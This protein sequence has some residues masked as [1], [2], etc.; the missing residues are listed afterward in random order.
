MSRS[1]IQMVKCRWREFRREPS[2]FFFVITMPLMWM[3]ILGYSFSEPKKETF[4]I[5]IIQP[6]KVT[7]FHTQ[8]RN[9]LVDRHWLKIASGSENE[10]IQ[11]L[12]KEEISL[13]VSTQ[14]SQGKEEVL[15]QFNPTHPEGIRTRRFVNDLVQSSFGRKEFLSTQDIAIRVEGSRYV[16]F[17]IPG[18][19]ALSLF[20]TS[21]FGTGMTLVASRREN[22]FKR[23]M[24]TP[25]NTFSYLLSHIVGRCII[26]A[27]EFLVILI[28]GAAI[29]KF[30]VAGNL[31]SY[32]LFALLGTFTFTSISI[33]CGSRARNA[34][35]YNGMVNLVTLPMMLLS[36]VWFP[37]SYFPDWVSR[38]SEFLPLT[39]LV[40]GLRHIAL[41]GGSISSLSMQIS[42]LLSY[43]V[44]A[45][46]GAKLLFKWY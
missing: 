42:V 2:A 14:E 46:L 5:G 32:L 6:E 45:T 30:S 10:L 24:T 28:A 38:L 23:Y 8:L 36:G 39:A 20:T 21:L 11:K 17:L 43:L 19:L 25:M 37:R 22:L 15:Y 33:L 41:E 44:V 34:G 40:D 4:S 13:I 1:F 27:I 3:I 9:I 29:F 12:K 18:L 16:D 7:A 35:L 26:F 31:L